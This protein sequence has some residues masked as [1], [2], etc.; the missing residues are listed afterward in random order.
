[1]LDNKNIYYEKDLYGHLIYYKNRIFCHVLDEWLEYDMVT[2]LWVRKAVIP[3]NYWNGARNLYSYC[4]YKQYILFK[5]MKSG[6]ICALNID[7]NE[8]SE[9][10]E[11]GAQPMNGAGGLVTIEKDGLLYIFPNASNGVLLIVDESLNK[12]VESKDW[13]RHISERLG[14][15]GFEFYGFYA[16]CV[17][18]YGKYFYFITKTDKKDLLIEVDCKELSF[19]RIL[20]IA[21]EGRYRSMLA[22]HNG[23]W[24]CDN[25][26][27]DVSR[28]VFADFRE[29]FPCKICE[30]ASTDKGRAFF[31]E[32]KGL[33]RWY[34]HQEGDA[35]FQDFDVEESGV[36]VVYISENSAQIVNQHGGIEKTVILG[37]ELD[38][39]YIFFCL[40][41]GKNKQGKDLYF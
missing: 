9:L 17:S 30:E 26:C 41:T 7:T 38:P 21:D 31:C 36:S 29:N 10:Y 14:S 20:E 2:D 33:V 15:R 39:L 4:K 23:I 5:D 25:S 24:L 40:I 32:S 37:Q 1:M 27:S 28:I 16:K 3:I 12:I 13:T 19:I 34:W 6:N 35:V 22:V 18:S 8:I 11:D